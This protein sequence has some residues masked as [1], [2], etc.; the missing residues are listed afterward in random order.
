MKRLLIACCVVLM[1]CQTSSP[2]SVSRS[3]E[4][5]D[6]GEVNGADDSMS[7]QDAEVGAGGDDAGEGVVEQDGGPVMVDEDAGVSV[8]EDAG[9]CFPTTC[10]GKLLEC[11]DCLDNDGDGKTDARDPECLGPCDNTEGPGL[12]AGVGGVN[13]A[14]CGVDCY[15][16]FGNGPG[17]DDCHW[18]HRCD[19]LEPEAECSFDSDRLG[20]RDCPA[21][22]SQQCDDFCRPYTPNGC[23]CFGC[24][25]FEAL[26][27]AGPGGSDTHVW[28]GKLDEDNE[29]ACTF[30]DLTNELKCP[31][32][33]P[34]ES[35]F[36]DCG[37]CEVCIGKPVVPDDCF[38]GGDDPDAGGN[39]DTPADNEGQC[40]GGEQPCGQEG[41]AECERSFYCI[42]GCCQFIN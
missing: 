23:D 24:C 11:G 20:G 22:Q 41:Q 39:G 21:E 37:R 26:R 32:C 27:G 12:S 31:R 1:S 5:E 42:T 17:N 3:S 18:D 4:S 8:D 25:T 33:T 34:V 19:P 28:I 38:E 13:R 16:D 9:V 29:S 30:D 7:P 10:A 6:A 40:P 2:S 14:N 35:C 36:N 15:F